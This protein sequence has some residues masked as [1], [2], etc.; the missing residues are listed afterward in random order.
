MQYLHIQQ[1][2]RISIYFFFYHLHSDRQVLLIKG[3]CLSTKNDF[4]CCKKMH[5]ILKINPK[6]YPTLYVSVD[7]FKVQHLHWSF[8]FCRLDSKQTAALLLL[9]LS[10]LGEGSQETPLILYK[11]CHFVGCSHHNFSKHLHF[12]KTFQCNNLPP[13]G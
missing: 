6:N 7:T 9:P 10:F 1:L 2:Q 8:F 11:Y 4:N 5:I 12:L 13:K 3:F